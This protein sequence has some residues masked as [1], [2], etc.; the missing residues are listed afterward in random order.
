MRP[1]RMRIMFSWLW[2]NLTYARS[3]TEFVTSPRDM[4][5]NQRD[6]S[7]NVCHPK[8]IHMMQ[9]V[10]HAPT[11]YNICNIRPSTGK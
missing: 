5:Q 1:K 6:Y 10:I 2:E 8:E 7:N 4:K 11:A 3:N 9:S